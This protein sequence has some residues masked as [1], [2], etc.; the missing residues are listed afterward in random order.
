MVDDVDVFWFDI[1]FHTFTACSNKPPA[2]KESCS[3]STEQTPAIPKRN[4]HSN[5]Q[6]ALPR[7]VPKHPTYANPND[8]LQNSSSHGPDGEVFDAKQPLQPQT[9]I[10]L[11]EMDLHPGVAGIPSDVP[12]TNAFSPRRLT[13]AMS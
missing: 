13:V 10:F 1:L 7:L 2:G 4:H 3:P 6:P 12:L 11:K 8:Q 5:V 9:G